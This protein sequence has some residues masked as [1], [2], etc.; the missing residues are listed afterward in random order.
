MMCR[1][2]KTT[3][4]LLLLW[5]LAGQPLLGAA[6]SEERPRVH[7]ITTGGTIANRTGDRLTPADLLRS[8][9]TLNLYVRVATEQFANVPSSSLTLDQ[10]VT[11]SQ[12]INELF[13]KDPD[14]SGIVVT[15]G[16][17]T[18]EEIAYFLHLTVKS[19]RP[20][21]VVGSMRSP[22]IL[23]Y[24]GAANLL[25]AFRVA[26][27]SSSQG[28][29]VLVVLNS[30][31]N[32]AREVT[33]VRTQGLN[34]FG[35]RGYGLL[36]VVNSDRIVF[37]RNLE[38][39]HTITSEFNIASV[40]TLPR[41]DILMVYQDASGDLISASVEAGARGIVIASAG[42]GSVSDSQRRAIRFARSR[43]VF[44]VFST[45]TGG[46]HV[47]MNSPADGA[48]RIGQQLAYRIPGEDLAP[49]KA[50]I[51]LMLALTKTRNGEEIARMF[52]EY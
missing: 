46:G 31:I 13:E 23:G 48:G 34:T 28:R 19:K 40:E 51:L 41:V 18:L 21:V 20:V 26:A 7:L 30:E 16:T 4:A 3:H 35:T 15:S 38:R 8:I 14:L 2:L 44:V 9:P 37:Y 1:T 43:E 12:R 29:G 24:D 17:D 22:E 6:D 39:R 5:I 11:L 49:L 50:R 42:A 27:E 33:K 45:R 32:S 25:E 36:G 10:W 52:R 47:S